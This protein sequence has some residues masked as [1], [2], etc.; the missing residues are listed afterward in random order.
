[1]YKSTPEYAVKPTLLGSLNHQYL[2]AL[3]VATADAGM[4]A[5]SG[6]VFYP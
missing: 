1:M 4:L 6:L 5:I 2:N 3:S